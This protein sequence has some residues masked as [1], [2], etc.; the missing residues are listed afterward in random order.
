MAPGLQE[1]IQYGVNGFFVPHPLCTDGYHAKPPE[2]L[3]FT[4][5]GAQKHHAGLYLFCIYTGSTVM[6]WFTEAWRASAMR[7]DMG[8][9]CVRVRKRY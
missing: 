3:P 2:P 6:Q 1:G 8:K 4:G 9:A 7:L 5:F